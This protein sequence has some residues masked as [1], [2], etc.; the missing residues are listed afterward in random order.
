MSRDL[1][2]VRGPNHPYRVRRFNWR[3]VFAEL[4]HGSPPPSIRAVAKNWNLPNDTVR[5][6]W[7]MYQRALLE[8]DETALAIACGDVDGRRDSFIV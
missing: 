2:R 6:H 3:P 4:S 7:R 5:K 1:A 8:N